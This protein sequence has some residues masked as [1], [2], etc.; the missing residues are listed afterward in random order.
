LGVTSADRGNGTFRLH[1]IA[2]DVDGHS[3]DLG[4]KTITCANAT[5]TKPFGAIDTPA[6][7]EVVSGAIPNF[8]WVLAR[9][10]ALAFPPNGTVRVVIDGVFGGSP[11]GWTNRSDITALFPVGTYPGVANAV[12]VAGL[13]TTTL[14]NGVHTIAWV[15][16]ADNGQ[17]DGIGS[18]FFTVANGLAAP[19]SVASVAIEPMRTMTAVRMDA[20]ALAD[21]VNAAPIDRAPITARRGYNIDT[22]FGTIAVGPSDRATV[23]SEE[24][25]R[26][27][28]RL[29]ESAGYEQAGYL[30]AGIATLSELL[31]E[32]RRDV[33][34]RPA[35]PAPTIS[36]CS[37]GAAS[38][39]GSC[40]PG[41][42]G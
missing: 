38:R 17:A 9:T 16:T 7:G 13:N 8:G 19:A 10:P 32:E 42:C 40:R 25:D 30:R 15:V 31:A 12:G 29:G 33:R 27:E 11:A 28:I 35:V 41:S 4:T 5:A 23:Q 39:T 22:P 20:G 36:R 3:V 1:A 21:E 6:Q 34:P 26:I 37:R 14:T 2:D 24:M 18:R